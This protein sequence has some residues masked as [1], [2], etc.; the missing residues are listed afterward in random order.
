MSLIGPRFK[1]RESFGHACDL[2]TGLM[3]GLAQKNCWTIAEH[4]G[5]V[6]PYGLQNL[7]SRAS[8]DH[9]GVRDDARDYVV[10]HL[11]DP[12]GVLVADETGDLKKGACT[13][14][15]QRQYTGTAGRVE[16]AQVSVH[17]TYTSS[18][19]HALIDAELYL[20]QSWTSDADRLAAAGVPDEVGFATKPQLAK[21]MITRAL[22]AEVPAS[23]VTADEVYGASIQL[24]TELESRQI[25]YALAVACDHRII[26]GAGQVRVDELPA[27]LP[28]LS[29]QE[30]SAGQGAKG[31][32]LYQWALV[33]INHDA[34]ADHPGHRWLLIRRNRTTGDLAYYR[35]YSPN[36][37]PLKTL[38]KVAGSRWTIEESFQAGKGLCGLDQH[39][40]RTWTSWRRWIILSMLAFAFLAA[41]TAREKTSP[42]A[43][44]IPL[45]CNEV[46]HLLNTHTKALTDQEHCLRWS[47]WRRRHQHH[48]RQCHYQ[49]RNADH[50]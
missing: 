18:A 37:V 14:G 27:S 25:G 6:T 38:V 7:L 43:G 3:S 8:W 32:R 35:C 40:L 42:P 33:D 11:G 31:P 45:T 2:V 22:D 47:R 28:R 23:W 46:A 29:W 50:T 4:A 15:V 16:N 48:A 39:Q 26:T 19:G 49:R 13:V 24:R 21:Q 44:M 1:R 36:P 20:P 10:E 41:Q 17:L 12:E 5:D 34:A 30:R 9:D